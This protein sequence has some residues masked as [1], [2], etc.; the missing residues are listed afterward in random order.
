MKALIFGAL[1]ALTACASAPE[2][3]QGPPT[4]DIAPGQAVP[5]QAHFYADCVAQSAAARNYDREGNV[6]RFHCEGAPARVFFDGLGPYSAEVGSEI[7]AMGRTWRFST[8]I[9]QNPSFVDF[10]RRQGEGDA[11]RYD[12]TVVLNV[13]EFLEH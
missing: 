5:A 4:L 2:P 1:F 6:I 10:C 11:A 13:G 12:C 7:V 9:R 3:A 8:P